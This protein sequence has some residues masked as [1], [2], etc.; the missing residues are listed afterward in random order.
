MIHAIKEGSPS[1]TAIRTMRPLVLQ[2]PFTG[3]LDYPTVQAAVREGL[4]SFC[5]LPLIS[6][7]R[8]IGTLNLGRLRDD[9]FSE[10]DLHFLG[11]VARQEIGRASCRERV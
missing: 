5:Y 6:R 10:E 2:S 3:W 1:R 7:D 11:Q 9:A 8:A 4:K